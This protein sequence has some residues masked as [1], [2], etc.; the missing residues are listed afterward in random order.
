MGNLINPAP[1]TYHAWRFEFVREI[2]SDTIPAGETE[3][4]NYSKSI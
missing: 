2:S 3:P 1:C 4:S